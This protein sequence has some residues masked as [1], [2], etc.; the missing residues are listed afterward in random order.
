MPSSVPHT[1]SHSR[2]QYRTSRTIRSLSTS[3]AISV[4]R[5]ALQTLSEGRSSHTISDPH[6]D[7]RMT[8]YANGATD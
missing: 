8:S 4:L 5:I 3:C 1:A 7:Y 2:A 6:I